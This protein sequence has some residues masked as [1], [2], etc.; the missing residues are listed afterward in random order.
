M[1]TKQPLNKMVKELTK[2]V[3][4]DS[5]R[6]RLAHSFKLQNIFE[7]QLM[8]Y[9]LQVL[10]AELQPRAYERIIPRVVPIN[11]LTRIVNK[12][13]KL[14]SSG[15]VAR[16]GTTPI[17]QEIMDLA[18]KDQKLNTVFGH[19]NKMYS[20][21]QYN[22]VEPYFHD[23]KMKT[24]V[25]D[26]SQFLIYSDDFVSKEMS[27][28]L[29]YMGEDEDGAQL[30]FAYSD[31]EFLAFDSK[32]NIRGEYMVDAN[33]IPITENPY[34]VIPFILVNQYSTKLMAQIDTSVLEMTLR[35]PQILSDI[36]YGHK[37]TAFSHLVGMDV[38]PDTTLDGS[39]DSFTIVHSREGEGVK[40]SIEVIKPSIDIPASLQLVT[41][42]LG[43][44]LESKGIKSGSIGQ[45]D[46]SLS[47]ISKILDEM[48][49]FQARQEQVDVF[50]YMEDAYW[51]LYAVMHNLHLPDLEESRA[52][53]K[54][55]LN[56]I[57][58]PEQKPLEDE[59]TKLNRVVIKRNNKLISQR[60]ALKE[61][62]PHM[63]VDQ[64]DA[65]IIEIDEESVVS[66]TPVI[67]EEVL[68]EE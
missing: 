58:F 54:D 19:G 34:G 67:E 28:F 17:D 25:L 65:L 13:S 3:D 39:P 43:L 27:V 47:G 50:R 37:F 16:E 12:L 53:S 5:N 56:S 30:W 55:P 42:Q 41:S 1:K 51:Q 52:M 14:Y 21:H 31:D 61:A 49:T 62:N 15:E 11:I 2:Y 9:L 66:V 68:D 40:G 22:A 64:I 36:N 10:K 29:K 4:G 20:L 60:L 48:D 35:I 38:D 63:D 59:T 33:G 57:K 44:W 32:G 8:P 45:A 6:S 7:G 46:A 23:N 18:V 24:R 26:P